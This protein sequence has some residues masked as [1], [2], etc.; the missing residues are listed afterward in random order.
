MCSC[1]V[2]LLYQQKVI[3]AEIHLVACAEAGTN[4]RFQRTGHNPRALVYKKLSKETQADCAICGNALLR[5]STGCAA[6]S[7]F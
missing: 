2:P 4:F 7:A 5:Q 1:L 3:A 6:V